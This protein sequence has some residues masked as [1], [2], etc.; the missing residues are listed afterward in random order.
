M[1]DMHGGDLTARKWEAVSQLLEETLARPASEREA[2]LRER[3]GC[4]RG[5]SSPKRTNDRSSRQ[6][7][8][9]LIGS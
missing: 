3:C 6:T 7:R 5:P 9:Q 2:F 1:A 4:D 8:R